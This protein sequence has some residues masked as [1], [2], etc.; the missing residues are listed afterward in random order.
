MIPTESPQLRVPWHRSHRKPT[1][2]T[3]LSGTRRHDCYHGFVAPYKLFVQVARLMA[4]VFT[5]V[6][7]D[8]WTSEKRKVDSSILSLTTDSDQRIF[9]LSCENPVGRGWLPPPFDGR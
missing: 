6:L 3:A 4:M 2:K 7:S 8:E 5:R 1:D 9:A